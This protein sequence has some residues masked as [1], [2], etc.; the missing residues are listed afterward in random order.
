MWNSTMLDTRDLGG[1]AAALE[2]LAGL[3]PLLPPHGGRL[4]VMFT[5]I[6]GF[7]AHAARRG[8]GAALGL[9]ARHDAVVLPAVRRHRGRIVKRLGDGLL[10]VFAHPVDALAAGLAM[11]PGAATERVALGIGVHAGL[12]RLRE[13]DLVG[14]AVNVAARIAERAGRGELVVSGAVRRA[15]GAL[16]MRLRRVRPL[17]LAGRGQ[18]PL[19][20][21][22]RN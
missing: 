7:T 5:D 13:G 17:V 16:A 18:I 12:V 1:R 21:T 22:H 20:A 14:H 15:G 9:L 8:D 10:A 19:F 6:R 2:W 11:L 4:T 3:F